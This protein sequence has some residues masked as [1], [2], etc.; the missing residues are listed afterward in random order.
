MGY[1]QYCQ[2]LKR[3][4]ELKEANQLLCKRVGYTLFYFLVM[5]GN[6]QLS[7]S[8]TEQLFDLQ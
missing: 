4:P 2:N 1:Y 6:Q 3:M 5:T 7:E 8:T